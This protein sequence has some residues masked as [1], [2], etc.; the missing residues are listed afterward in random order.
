MLAVRRIDMHKARRSS[1][2]TIIRVIA[3]ELDYWTHHELPREQYQLE[4]RF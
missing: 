2:H 1:L 4:H 3:N